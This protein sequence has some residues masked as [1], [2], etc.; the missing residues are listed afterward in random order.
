MTF[1]YTACS[2]VTKFD[3]VYD[4]ISGR[5]G[6]RHGN[7]KIIVMEYVCVLPDADRLRYIDHRQVSVRDSEN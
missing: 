6:V 3:S 4:S 5:H 1:I 7:R 2:N